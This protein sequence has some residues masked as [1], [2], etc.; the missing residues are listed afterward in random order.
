MLSGV[1]Q[2]ALAPRGSGP[3]AAPKATDEKL[4]MRLM[5][6]FPGAFPSSPNAA[7]KALQRGNRI[8]ARENELV[9]AGGAPRRLVNARLARERETLRARRFDRSC[10]R[11]RLCGVSRV[12]AAEA[13]ERRVA[14]LRRLAASS[15]VAAS[16]S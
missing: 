3:N 13:G 6:W 10:E 15:A 1:V 5:T 2:F 4:G 16:P 12:R 14:R 9:D 11:R 7:I 8:G